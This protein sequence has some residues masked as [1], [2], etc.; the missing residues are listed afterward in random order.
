[1]EIFIS[2]QCHFPLLLLQSSLPTCSWKGKRMSLAAGVRL[3][4]GGGAVGGESLEE[5]RAA[6]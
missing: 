4:G 1:M 3:K 2:L 5:T 6:R